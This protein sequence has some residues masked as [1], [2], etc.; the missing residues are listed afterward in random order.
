MVR[1]LIPAACLHKVLKL[2][3]NTRCVNCHNSH[4]HYLC[5]NIA[6]QNKSPLDID[7][8][9]NPIL[10]LLCS[11]GEKKPFQG[12]ASYQIFILWQKEEKILSK[13]RKQNLKT[14]IIRALIAISKWLYIEGRLFWESSCSSNGIGEHKLVSLIFQRYDANIDYETLSKKPL[15]SMK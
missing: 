9:V 5:C 13:Q 15:D 2:Y 3:A 11:G 14:I 10:L 6:F 4:F 1:T 8:Q 12:F 7:R